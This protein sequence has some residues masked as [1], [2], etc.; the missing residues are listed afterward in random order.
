MLDTAAGGDLIAA[1][2]DRTAAQT[3]MS[4]F[5]EDYFEKTG[6]LPATPGDNRSHARHYLRKRAVLGHSG[7]YYGVYTR[8]LSRGGV[9]VLCPRQLL[10]LT[11][12]KVILS[13]QANFQA[14]VR[15]CRR[16]DDCCYD[17]GCQI[18]A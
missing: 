8:D 18:R 1:L 14:I 4:P 10:P 12:V 15:W 2:W 13:A 9:G 7:A 6:A 16:V 11:E 17:V 3:D 5:L